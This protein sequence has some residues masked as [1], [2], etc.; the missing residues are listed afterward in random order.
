M[1]DTALQAMCSPRGDARTQ[2]GKGHQWWTRDVHHLVD[3]ETMTALCGRNASDWL[4]LE[5][6]TEEASKDPCCC[7]RCADSFEALPF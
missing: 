7:L 2:S 1:A 3:K 4:A 5:T 6:D